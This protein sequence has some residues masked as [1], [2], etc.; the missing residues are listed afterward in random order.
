MKILCV[1][2]VTNVGSVVGDTG[3]IEVMVLEEIRDFILEVVI[4]HREY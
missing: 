4:H 1:A 2:P 3:T